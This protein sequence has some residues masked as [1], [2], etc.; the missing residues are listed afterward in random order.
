L[1]NSHPFLI[2][3]FKKQK[4]I[5]LENLF[6][7]KIV[8]SLTFTRNSNNIL[9]TFEYK[10]SYLQSCLTSLR[11]NISQSLVEIHPDFYDPIGIQLEKRF[12]EKEIL[13]KFL[14]AVVHFEFRFTFFRFLFL[15]L[16]FELYIYVGIKMREWLHWKFD[17]T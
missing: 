12:H 3:S 9:Q 13:N 11:L 16:T 7:Q 14:T 15:L 17:Y 5:Y 2:D 1:K 8:Y 4:S 10:N 6:S